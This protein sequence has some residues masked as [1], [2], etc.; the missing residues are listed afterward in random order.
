MA[1]V[2]QW[3]YKE[4]EE[5]ASL[6]KQHP[7]IGIANV[8]S[9]PAPQMQQMR[10]NLRENMTIRSSKNTLIFRSIDAAEKD[11]DGLKNL[12]EIIEGQSAIIATDINP[13]KLQSRMKKTRTK[14]PAKGGEIAPE[15][16][17]VQAGDTPFKPG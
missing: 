8:G 5:L 12:K 3:K 6:L 1:H 14:A 13:F 2:A 9:I 4:V 11:V 17:K 10:Q 7:V 16:I 15:D